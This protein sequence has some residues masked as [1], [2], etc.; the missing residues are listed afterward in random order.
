MKDQL[1]ASCGKQGGPNTT[2]KDAY[3]L[4]KRTLPDFEEYFASCFKVQTALPWQ[5]KIF[6]YAWR[7]IYTTNIDNVLN[8]AHAATS[9]TG[10]TAGEFQFFNYLDE[11]L[12]SG[13]IGTIPVVTIHGTCL[14]LDEGFV[15]STL[16]YAKVSTRILDWHN[17]LA[18]RIIAGGLVVIGNQLD[19]SDLDTYV[20]HRQ[21]SY[22]DGETSG[23]W[24]VSPN[25]DPIKAENW[26]AAGFYVITATA[27]QFF[28]ELFS[29]INPRS[30]GDIALESVPT[31]KRAVKSVK[32]MTW[33]K[34][35]FQLAFDSIEAAQTQKGILKHFITGADPEW[36]YIVNDAHARTDRGEELTREI[37]RMMQSNEKGVGIL[38]V[39]GPSGSG[40]TTAI[41][42][43]I[44]DLARSYP[45]I[46]E[47]DQNQSLD[48]DLLRITTDGF[49]DKSIFIFH[50]A[51]EYY[52]AIKAIADRDRTRDQPYCLFIL[53]DR[54]SDHRRNKRQL[55]GVLLPPRIIEFGDLHLEDAQNIAVK[56]EE[57]GLN[58]DKFSDKPL[59][60][61]ARIILDKEKGY[62]GDLLSALYS[63]TTHENF[64]QKIFQDY[65]SA[66][67]E[68]AHKVLDLVSILHSLGYAVPINYIAG[69]LNERFED[70]AKCVADDLAGII[71]MPAGTHL[72][73]CRHRV[74]ATYYFDNHIA[75]N[76]NIEMLLGLLEF[77][78][79][80]LTI[81]DIRLHPLQ[82]R[83][84]RDIIS[85][86]FIYEK[87][88]SASNRVVEAE[89]LYHLAQRW[90][91][92][93]GIFW[94]QFGRFYREINKLP[95]AIDCLRT[96]L[97]LY[98]SFQ[99]R[100]SLG[101]TLLEQYLIK[102]NLDQ[103]DEGV[104]LLEFERG[105]RPDDPYPTS[106]LL[107]LL[108]RILRKNPSNA[109]AKR[110]AS[111]CFNSGMK[112][113][114][115]DPYFREI[116]QEYMQLAT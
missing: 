30:I 88:C 107:H 14:K 50:S 69:A 78:S 45:Y 116:A 6:E 56:I 82:Y 49:T 40:K 34:S 48:Q 22:G 85:I 81:N 98:D 87:F 27:E 114:R 99:T 46:Y 67:S 42:N 112:R 2:L 77:L 109:D 4:A 39:I 95:E 111:D 83:I 29:K 72:V 106:T 19:E 63:L 91:G 101:L 33:F 15:F 11:G 70:V 32:A 47:F 16:E 1:L 23:N 21:A 75:Q 73:K 58:F 103:Y 36:L 5:Q 60:A 80:Q 37:A 115:D 94:L 96:G 64:E 92:S 100:H 68:L 93:D 104:K 18:A 54:S 9:A 59:I 74:I 102:P 65:Q 90:F 25:P 84:Y 24:I 12:I 28:T 79:R 26:T 10:K 52:Y 89:R 7:R 71:Q 76:G 97:E 35:A 20:S 53:E 55:N 51:A 44:R 31:V 66:Q 13:T 110:R 113:F 108:V 41:R 38:H 62:G 105:S 8:I 17:D 61:R 43:S 57:A 3:Q 86:G